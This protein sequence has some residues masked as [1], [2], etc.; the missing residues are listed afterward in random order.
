M[1]PLGIVPRAS[2][3]IFQHIQSDKRNVEYSI[4]AGFVEIYKE[5]VLDLLRPSDQCASITDC[6]PEQPLNFIII[7]RDLKIRES[8]QKGVWIEGLNEEFVSCEED[9]LGV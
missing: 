9:I 5:R 4:R 1:V 2:R 3:Q 6:P 8:P 7:C